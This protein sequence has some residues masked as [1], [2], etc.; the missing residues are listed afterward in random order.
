MKDG[1]VPMLFRSRAARAKRHSASQLVPY[2]ENGEAT[3][4]RQRRH[5]GLNCPD[6]KIQ[7]ILNKDINERSISPWRYRLDENEDRYPRQLAFA[8]CLCGG[9][10]DGKTGRETTSLN[11]VPVVQK[12]VVLY[13]KPCQHDSET[14]GFTF[15]VKDILVPVACACVLPRSSS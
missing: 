4:R 3:Q 9:C 12:M 1:E 14:P 13:R 6:L 15:E 8:E 2:L 11:S 10:I 7:D 5:H